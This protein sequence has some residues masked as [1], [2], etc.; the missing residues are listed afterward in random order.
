M[1][2]STVRHSFSL[3]WL[4]LGASTLAF[5]LIWL[6]LPS[7]QASRLIPPL[8]PNHSPALPTTT[9]TVTNTNADGG[10]NVHRVGWC[11]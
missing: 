11:V 1:K 7:A 4:G 9:Y 8:L 6:A 2:T 10:F 5:T 3:K